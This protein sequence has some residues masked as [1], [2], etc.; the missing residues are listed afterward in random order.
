ML[1]NRSHSIDCYSLIW[2]IEFMKI[3]IRECESHLCFYPTFEQKTTRMLPRLQHHPKAIAK[4]A[5][6]ELPPTA[7]PLLAW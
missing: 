7:A 4:L 2:H 6:P 1:I 5:G 3:S